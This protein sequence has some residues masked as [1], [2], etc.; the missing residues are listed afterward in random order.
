MRETLLA[1]YD[2]H[3]RPLPWRTQPS[4]YRT[5]LS[6]FMLQQTQ[7]ATV[8]PYFDRWLQKFPSFD[9]LAA[10][11]EAEVLKA[12]EGLGY[13][14]RARNLQKLARELASM[15]APPTTYAEWIKLPGIGPYTAAAVTSI[16]FQQ[17]EAVVDG[18]VIRVLARI[19]AD[20][21]LHKDAAAATK[22]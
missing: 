1:W 13:Y 5:V 18:N 21:S 19:T 17:P 3:Q 4:L 22:A 14:S 16:A 12:W 15:D 2:E 7:V 9:I 11:E 8:L 10:A 6:E 20:D